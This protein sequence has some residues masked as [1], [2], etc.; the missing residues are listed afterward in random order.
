[1][2]SKSVKESQ[3]NFTK[4]QKNENCE[5]KNNLKM[6]IAIAQ[7]KKFQALLCNILKKVVEISLIR[8]LVN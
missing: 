7:L 4:H 1:M 6:Q 8:L 2:E 3:T 5:S